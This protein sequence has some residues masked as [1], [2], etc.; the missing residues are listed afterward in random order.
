MTEEHLEAVELVGG[1][2]Q[3]PPRGELVADNRGGRPFRSARK[4]SRPERW[5]RLHGINLDT[6]YTTGSGDSPEG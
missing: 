1:E 2:V 3:R 4:T 6:T 5:Y